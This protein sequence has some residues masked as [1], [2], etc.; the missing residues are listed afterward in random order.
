MPPPKQTPLIAATVGTARSSNR[1]NMRLTSRTCFATSPSPAENIAPN[2]V[3]SAPT[4]NTGLP[5]VSTTPL[6]AESFAIAFTAASRSSSA[7][8][9]S[10][11]TD[12]PAMSNFSSTMPS[13]SAVALKAG[14]E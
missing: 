11:L 9:F 2:S 1:E 6:T 14:P 8:R 12:S 3:M 5:E 4:M 13:P 10:L 7:A